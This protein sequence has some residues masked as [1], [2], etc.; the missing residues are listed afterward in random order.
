MGIMGEHAPYAQHAERV[1]S[2]TMRLSSILFV[3]LILLKQADAEITKAEFAGAARTPPMVRSVFSWRLPSRR[4]SVD[5]H[6]FHT[7]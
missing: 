2:L 4:D 7:Q 3:L 1:D 5:S 6:L